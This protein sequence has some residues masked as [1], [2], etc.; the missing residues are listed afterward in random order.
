LLITS[1][2]MTFVILSGGIDLSVGAVIA[3]TTV[4]SAF[5]LEGCGSQPGGG[6]P[7]SCCSLA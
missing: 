3:F 6:D 1:I 2:G 5:L 4:F 7:H